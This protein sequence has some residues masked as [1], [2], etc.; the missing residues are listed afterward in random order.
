MCAAPSISKSKFLW[1]LQCPKLLWTA[2]NAKDLIPSPDAATQAIFD[3]GHEVGALAKQLFPG[4]IEVSA[5]V[6]DFDQ[7]LRH[8]L[9][10]AKARK[11]LF[12]PGFAYNGGFA[13]A[14]IL[15]PVGRD[16]WDFIELKSSTEVKDVNLLDVAFQAFVYN[17]AGLIIRRCVLMHIDKDFTRHGPVDP[18]SFFKQA[19]VTASVSGL[20]RE[21]GD[22]LGEMAKV[23]RQPACP[24]IRIGPHCDDPY[25]CP[26]HDQCW[27][28]L[29]E[30]NVTTLYRGGKKAFKLLEDGITSLT[31]IPD[32]FLLTENQQLQRRAAI[33][34]QPHVDR[35]TIAAFLSQLKYPLSFMDF[36]TLGTAI[37]LFDGVKPYQQVP[38]QFSLHVVPSAGAKPEHLGF[39][40]DGRSDPRPE[41][42]R[43]LRAVLP[44]T[45]SVVVY[46][47]GFERSRL[48]EC[49][50]FLLEFKPWNRRLQ[51]R[52][53]DLLLPFRGFRYYHPAQRG[54]AS[55]KAVLPAL[56]GRGYE[57]LA[58]QEGGTASLEFLRV[59]FDDVAEDERQRVRRQLEKI[60]R[61][62]RC[63]AAATLN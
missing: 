9:E 21:V 37:P 20:S 26:L 61:T 18:R 62:P 60:L 2:Y 40:A 10:A 59:T 25:T 34:G 29:P 42:M 48:D 57:H 23:I 49:C 54:S 43:R 53:V 11:P 30:Q 50:E 39:L 19:D 56:T 32:D 6:T 22:Q 31:D 14:D 35:P 5:G 63:C 8:S 16:E 51:R 47:A 45:G 44:E 58:I 17:G 55:M 13:R 4:G 28:F 33:A 36:E 41:F 24:D 12:E 15:N 7:V 38:F 3:Q 1:G 52:M 27:A 46:N